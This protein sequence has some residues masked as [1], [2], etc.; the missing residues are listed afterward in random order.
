[1]HME[2]LENVQQYAQGI[3]DHTDSLEPPHLPNFGFGYF[4]FYAQKHYASWIVFY[5]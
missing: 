4:F 3:S 5:I 2:H 1:M